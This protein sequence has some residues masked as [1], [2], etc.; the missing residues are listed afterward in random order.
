MA[1]AHSPSGAHSRPTT[2]FARMHAPLGGCWLDG[3][4]TM[5][6]TTDCT[7]SATAGGWH[8]RSGQCMYALQ[9]RACALELRAELASMAAQVLAWGPRLWGPRLRMCGSTQAARAKNT[10]TPSTLTPLR[11]AMLH[12]SRHWSPVWSHMPESCM[13]RHM[14]PKCTVAAGC[15][16]RP[17]CRRQ[18]QQ[19]EAAL[20]L[21]P[22]RRVD[23]RRASPGARGK[24]LGCISCMG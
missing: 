22:A 13:C 23:P 17:P 15:E 5:G 18:P 12:P 10:C 24:I 19:V 3:C 21:A 16:A 4:S 7:L 8:P 2:S 1:D 11:S 9:A 20:L 6:G 14:C